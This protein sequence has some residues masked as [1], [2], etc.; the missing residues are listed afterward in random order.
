[1]L[2]LG[3]FHLQG[4]V[5]H[6]PALIFNPIEPAADGSE[7]VGLCVE[8]EPPASLGIAVVKKTAAIGGQDRGSDLVKRF[9]RTLMAP[10]EI[11]Q[12]GKS[13]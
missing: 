12:R 4:R 8:F 11:P 13:D 5:F 6:D 1:M 9:D 3:E 7:I 2:G 10:V